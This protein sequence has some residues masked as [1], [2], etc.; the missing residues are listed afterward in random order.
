M[1]SNLSLENSIRD[2]LLKRLAV[3]YAVI[4]VLLVII[5]LIIQLYEVRDLANEQAVESVNRFNAQVMY[6]L[7]DPA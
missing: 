5:V 1:T 2:I 6:I 4:A 3:V 7:D